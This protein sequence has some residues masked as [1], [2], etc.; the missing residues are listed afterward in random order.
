MKFPKFLEKIF[1]TPN[2]RFLNQNIDV[3]I[4]IGTDVSKDGSAPS[5][6]SKKIVQIANGHLLLMNGH[7]NIIYT[8]G[9]PS[10]YSRAEAFAMCLYHA[11]I[12]DLPQCTLF[13][14]NSS[15]RTYQ[16]ADETLKL[17]K[18]HRW[19]SALIVA[20]QLHARRVRATFWWRWNHRH[21]FPWRDDCGGPYR[22]SVI[23]ARSEYTG[24]NSQNRL[25]SFWKFLV[26]DTLTFVW[27]YWKR[28]C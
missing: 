16:N 7:K 20:Q 14:E 3:V 2:D 23:K 12:A 8:G 11:S 26:W 9:Y 21:W 25:T 10:T 1:E 27:S 24:D 18:E 15:K 5:P 6:Q 22:I 4:L 28:W 13:L 17:M 19:K